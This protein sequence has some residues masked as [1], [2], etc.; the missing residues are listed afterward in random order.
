MQ[1]C[2]CGF[3]ES[4]SGYGSGNSRESGWIRIQDFDDEKLKK[5]MQLKTFF[6][7]FFD[8]KL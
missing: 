4:G 3:T 5:K 1:S 6:T 7:S 2:G 8:Q